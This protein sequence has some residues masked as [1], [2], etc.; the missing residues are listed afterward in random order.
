MKILRSLLLLLLLAGASAHA[1]IQ[2]EA[3][4]YLDK[5]IEALQK[6][7]VRSEQVDWTRLRERVYAAAQNAKV[8]PD[9][10]P[11]LRLAFEIMGESFSRFMTPEETRL[12]R[13]G[14][15]NNIGLRAI[16]PQNVV[17]IVF[18][19]GPAAKAGVQ[20][21]DVIVSINKQPPQAD[22]QNAR[23]VNINGSKLELTLKRAD[24]T[25]EVSLE[26]IP[27]YIN[28]PPRAFR[29]GKVAYL[30]LPNHS[31]RGLVE[32][33]GLYG[34]LAHQAIGEVDH[35]PACGW[36]V[37]LRRNWG[38]SMYPMLVGAGP[39]VGE[40]VL[41]SFV[42]GNSKD[43][44][45]YKN[46]A[47]YYETDVVYAL[48]GMPAY[49]LKNPKPPVAVLI[50]PVTTSA[51][52]ATLMSFIG[53]GNVRFF[54]EPTSGRSLAN[55]TRE[56]PDGASLVI[57]SAYMA[58]RNGKV[59]LEAI[60]PDQ[61]VTTDWANFAGDKDPVLKAATEWLQTQSSCK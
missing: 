25:F 49:V 23:R 47:S 12:I 31:G 8:P 15:V 53:R 40:G 13:Q 54:G 29:V 19:G 27:V 1:Q 42:Y 38:G 17:A 36:V 22:P 24:R 9:T 7:F 58:D 46:G 6:E 55:S 43:K 30:E 59:Y 57:T 18:P 21:G 37:D 33:A 14:A 41:G 20:P 16:F 51:G 2:G 60:K 39:I 35:N 4:A 45:L 34:N 11:A 52:E 5:A 56:M 32:G 28:L 26:S 44:W 50:S 61:E 48:E 10:Y 3:K